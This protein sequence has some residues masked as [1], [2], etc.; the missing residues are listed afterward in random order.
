MTV[1]FLN[2]FS[3]DVDK[4]LRKSDKL[5][6]LKLIA[7]TEAAKELFDIPHIKKLV[8]HK[9]AYR[10]RLGDYRIGVF[11][12]LNKVVFARILHRKEIYKLFP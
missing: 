6:L 1:E 12:E 2:S 9:N 7:Q 5:K 10:V 11:Y 3:K 8:G 4:I